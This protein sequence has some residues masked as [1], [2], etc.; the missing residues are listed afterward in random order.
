MIIAD[1][2]KPTAA[3]AYYNDEVISKFYRR[4]WGGSDIHIGLYETGSE[5]VAAASAAMTRYL[6]D[7]SSVIGNE[8]VL[9]IA[10]GFGGTLRILAEMG[11]N[12]T[13]LDISQSCVEAARKANA[14][15]DLDNR[16]TVSLG[17]FHEINSDAVAWDAVICQESLIHSPNRPRVFAEVYRVLRPGGVFAFSDIL[18]SQGADIGLVEAAFARLRAD[19]GATVIDYET[20]ALQAGFALE[21]VEQR[22]KDITVHYN[23]LAE[24]LDRSN[25]PDFANIK[26]SVTR[27]QE[28]L[29]GGHITWACFVARKPN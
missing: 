25:D 26:M 2:P 23:K 8:R 9:D 14:A 15:A 1:I 4:I 13:G 6:I 12:V 21:F 11:C 7:R 19:A 10:C 3:A 22:P 27:W 28:A 16:I 5:T 29:A 20:M 24:A 17:D 18:A